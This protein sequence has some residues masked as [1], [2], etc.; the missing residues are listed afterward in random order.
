MGYVHNDNKTDNQKEKKKD[1]LNCKLFYITNKEIKKKKI[2][3]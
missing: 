2:E 3:I 1:L